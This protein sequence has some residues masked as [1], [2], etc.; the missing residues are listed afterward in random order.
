[1]KD[2]DKNLG[3]LT[4]SR[5]VFISSKLMI[6]IA[7]LSIII[8]VSYL[9]IS[10]FGAATTKYITVQDALNSSEISSK[11]SLGVIGKLVPNT[12]HRSTDGLTAYFSITDDESSEQMS[13][14]YSGE[15]GEIFFNENA[16]IIIQGTI[17]KDG[18]FKT[19]SLSIKCPS[20]YV[21]SLEESSDI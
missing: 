14:S 8:A 7:L 18:V 3:E 21:D 9:A 11:E 19:T 20:K 10:S 16:E 12:F 1:M 13:V 17:E 2:D 5:P 15:I 6:F 4:H